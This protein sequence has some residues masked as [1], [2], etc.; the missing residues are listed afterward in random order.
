MHVSHVQL[1]DFARGDASYRKVLIF[2]HVVICYIITNIEKAFINL[3]TYM[4][5]KA[6]GGIQADNSPEL[7]SLYE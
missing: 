3:E 2:G 6:I 5:G 4:V 7:G 1:F